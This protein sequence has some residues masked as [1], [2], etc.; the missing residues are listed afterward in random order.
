MLSSTNCVDFQS[1]MYL[2]FIKQ[3]NG[4]C[5]GNTGHLAIHK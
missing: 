1:F 5:V 3:R 4:L 2:C